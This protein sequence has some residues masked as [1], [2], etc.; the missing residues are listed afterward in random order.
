MPTPIAFLSMEDTKDFV[1]YDHLAVPALERAGFEVETVPWTVERDWSRYA[2]VVIR[3]P[4]DYMNQSERFLQ[5]LEEIDRHTQLL[6]GFA[7]VRWNIDKGYLAELG[8]KGLPVV[9]TTLGR[10]GGPGEQ[11]LWRNVSRDR[12]CVLKPRIG[13]GGFD[14]YV[15]RDGSFPREAG[16]AFVD[17]DWLLQPFL[18][19]VQ[20][21][22][23]Y[24]LFFFGGVYSHAVRKVPRKGEFRSQE[25]YGSALSAVTPRA[26]MLDAAKQV[27]DALPEAVFQA[28]VDLVRAAD[29][30]PLLMELELIEPSLYFPYD[31]TSPGNFARALK[32]WLGV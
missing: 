16:K 24:S 28:R 9:E 26:D 19:A 22:G 13:A 14:T 23:E 7:T 20:E 17:R 25:E 32:R 12:P 3:S 29:D 6:N 18:D 11:A 8:G 15:L 30:R 21:D 4:W 10:G 27:L 5:V 1:I 31:E 2:A